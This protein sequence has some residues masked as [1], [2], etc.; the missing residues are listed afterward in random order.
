[1]KPNDRR[2]ANQFDSKCVRTQ[3]QTFGIAE[4]SQ[5]L[6]NADFSLFLPFGEFLGL[7]EASDILIGS[8]KEKAEMVLNE[9]RWPGNEARV[10]STGVFLSERCWATIVKSGEK[11]FTGGRFFDTDVSDIGDDGLTP[12]E[13]NN[14]ADSRVNLMAPHHNTPS[15]GAFIYGDETKQGATSMIE[16]S[17]LDPTLVPLPSIPATCSVI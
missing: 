1:M 2:I 14:F 7:A 10:G 12:V 16:E 5:R 15:P 3:I 4:I 17:M 13:G 9:K 6:R 8:E 11:S